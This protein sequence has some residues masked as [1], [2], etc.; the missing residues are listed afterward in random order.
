MAAREQGTS[1][2]EYP[3]DLEEMILRFSSGTG[4]L[5]R[6]DYYRPIAV[7]FVMEARSSQNSHWLDQRWLMLKSP[8]IAKKPLSLAVTR[9][10]LLAFYFL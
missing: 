10:D 1:C 9:A 4:R 6:M 8:Q 3:S 7:V 2:L 5:Q